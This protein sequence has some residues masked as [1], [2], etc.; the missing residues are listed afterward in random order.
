MAALGHRRPSRRQGVQASLS[1]DADKALEVHPHVDWVLYGGDDTVYFLDD[2]CRALKQFDPKLPHVVAEHVWLH[3]HD[4]RTVPLLAHGDPSVGRCVP[5]GTHTQLR[6]AIPV[7]RTHS[8]WRP[9]EACPVCTRELVDRSDTEK[10]Y[11]NE[12]LKEEFGGLLLNEDSTIRGGAGMVPSRSIMNPL[13]RERMMEF[14]NNAKVT[15]SL[16]GGRLCLLSVSLL[17]GHRP[18]RDGCVHPQPGPRGV[19]DPGLPGQ[20]DNR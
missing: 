16:P 11:V 7:I 13:S 12:T 1:A 14:F 8:S 5:C 3:V 9:P 20:G 6:S 15:A 17:D 10:K 18:D 4:T 2:A 19:W